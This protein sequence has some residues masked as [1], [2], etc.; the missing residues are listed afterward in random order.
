MVT[1]KRLPNS[2]KRI[3][4]YEGYRNLF[5]IDQ[6]LKE[7]NPTG[8]FKDKTMQA[9]EPVLDRMPRKKITIGAIS[10]GNTAFSMIEFVKKYNGVMGDELLSAVIFIPH[11]LEN[12]RFFGPDM[13]GMTIPANE[14]IAILERGAK[15]IR[16][17]LGK[18]GENPRKRYFD[19]LTLA[20]KAFEAGFVHDDGLF[21][22]I[23][24]GLEHTRFLHDYDIWMSLNGKMTQ[25]DY[26]KMPKLGIR[27]YSPIIHKGIHEMR[28]RFGMMPDYVVCQFGAGIL[29][30]EIVYETGPNS[31]YEHHIDVIAISVGDPLSCADK[32]YP[33]YWVDDPANLRIRGCARSRHD[34]SSRVFGVED[35]E[36]GCAMKE[37]GTTLNAEASGIAGFA[38][39]NRLDKIVPW[40]DRNKHV[41]LTIN[42]GNGLPNFEKELK[43]RD[44][45]LKTNTSSPSGPV[46]SFF[47][48][49]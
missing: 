42:T 13:S 14:Y 44:Q 25:K 26:A 38:I 39:L 37:L 19:S 18:P 10:T 3:K 12:R 30:H 23:T 8:T 22:D 32:I 1:M 15:V 29:F 36:I 47:T 28:T 45:Q 16:L 2:V 35:W 43:N 33:S 4:D 46:L 27:S 7:L 49:P 5:C 9:L 6:S 20:Q 24:E 17:N 40:L 11:D 21:I 48:K 31:G 34:K 41:V